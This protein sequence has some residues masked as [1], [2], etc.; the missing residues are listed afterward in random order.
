[1]LSKLIRWLNGF[2]LIRTSNLFDKYWY[3]EKN[4]DVAQ[5]KVNPWLH[6]LR[7]GGFEGRDPG[8]SFS[9]QWYLDNNSDVKNARVN[10]LVHYLK[11]G[12]KEGRA[13]QPQSINTLE[14]PYKCPVCQ[15]QV[16]KFLPLSPFYTEN[17]EKYGFPYKQDEGE[18]IN[19]EQYS[20]PNCGAVDRDRLYACYLEERLSQHKTDSQFLLLDVAPSLPLS[21]FIKKLS[22]VT[23][24]TADMSMEGMTYSIDITDMPEIASNLYDVLICSHVLEHVNDDKKALS[25]LYRV[26]KPE[27]WGII[28]VPI[29][30]TLDQIDEDPQITDEAERWRRFGQF[31]HVRL[32]NKSGFVE[33][34]EAVGFS[35]K[36]LGINHFGESQFRQ[37]GISKTSVLYVVEKKIEL[38]QELGRTTS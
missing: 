2:F 21:R 5:A 8:P 17:L 9:S 12:K 1:M 3:L 29:I 36:Q 28:M 33:R 24:H 22:N 26:L 18:T 15:K 11:S 31:D 23:H 13:P 27:G 7:Y 34:M 32:Y 10:P 37:Y 6:Y 16:H 19:P 4:P 35:V 14:T 20:C 25:E 38:N 30:L